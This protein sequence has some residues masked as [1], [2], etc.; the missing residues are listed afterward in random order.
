LFWYAIAILLLAILIFGGLR[1]ESV[2]TVLPN[3]KGM[4]LCVKDVTTILKGIQRV[5]I[6]SLRKGPFLSQLM[7]ILSAMYVVV[8][9]QN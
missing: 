3:T 6:L 1:W 2:R 9:F 7:A 4:L 8:P 5:T